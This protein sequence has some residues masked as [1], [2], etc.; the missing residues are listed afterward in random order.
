MY[1]LNFSRENSVNYSFE[2]LPFEAPV[3]DDEVAPA[4][5]LHVNSTETSL[6]KL[7][8]DGSSKSQTRDAGHAP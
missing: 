3:D 5:R 2:Y 8:I 7:Q 4:C 6:I 1:D